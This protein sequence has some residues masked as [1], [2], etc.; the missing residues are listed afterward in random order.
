MS[1]SPYD[2]LGMSDDELRDEH[3]SQEL[4]NMAKRILIEAARHTSLMGDEIRDGLDALPNI[5]FWNDE[6][7]DARRAA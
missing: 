3:K 5:Q 1:V 7:I 6:I 2:H 4:V